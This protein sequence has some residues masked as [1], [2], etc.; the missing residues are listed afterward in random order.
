MRN[1]LII[2]IEQSLSFLGLIIDN[3]I[4][5]YYQEIIAY[6]QAKVAIKSQFA[7]KMFK[8]P[9]KGKSPK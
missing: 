9:K 4:V 3:N 1:A 5:T 7:I 6:I 8:G 2:T